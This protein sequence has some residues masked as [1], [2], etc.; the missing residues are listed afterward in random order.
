MSMRRL[1]EAIEF[2]TGLVC[3]G[4]RDEKLRFKI[5]EEGIHEIEDF[6]RLKRL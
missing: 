2:L 1:T 5:F 4:G 3:P 6:K